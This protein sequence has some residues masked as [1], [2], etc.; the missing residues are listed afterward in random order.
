METFQAAHLS[1]H[2]VKVVI[3]FLDSGF[4]SQTAD[5]RRDWYMALQH[6][7]ARAG[8]EGDVVLLWKDGSGATR[9]MAPPQQHAFF[10]IVSYDQLYAQVNQTLTLTGPLPED[11]AADRHGS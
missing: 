10:Q 11:R 6:D 8:L 4:D 7:A 9:F 5:R 2:G 3:V 1:I